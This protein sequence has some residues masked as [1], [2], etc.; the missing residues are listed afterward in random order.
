MTISRSY[1]G[2]SP[3]ELLP[4]F[5]GIATELEIGDGVFAD[6]VE[7]L[8]RF[9]GIATLPPSEVLP[10]RRVELLPRFKGIATWL[11]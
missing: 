7:L 1:I 3:V 9:K 6:V 10:L 5:K 8:P 2:H 4:R 11:N